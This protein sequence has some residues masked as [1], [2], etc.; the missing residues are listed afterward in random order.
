MEVNNT[1]QSRKKRKINKI[2]EDIKLNINYEK[3]DN[4]DTYGF[5]L[6][7]KTLKSDTKELPMIGSFVND[8]PDFF[9]LE[10]EVGLYHK[11]PKTGVCWFKD[12]NIIDTIDGL[13]NAILYKDIE[14]LKF[15]KTRYSGVNYFG[16]IDYSLCGDFDEE[17]L[18]H[19]IKRQCITYLWLTYEMEAI[20]FPL[21]TY[22]DERSLTWCFE[23]IMEGSNV[24]VSLK[25]VMT[26][27]EKA[28]FLKALRVLVDT[29]HPKALIVYTV[30]KYESTIQMLQ[31][32]I[33]KG[34]KIIEVPNTMM[35]KNRGVKNG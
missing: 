9:A 7:N 1:F 11:T 24:L 27:P 15:Y 22:G 21:M 12:E 10:P 32:A 19:N 35:N 25:M 34:V 26:G 2:N 5:Y 14:L 33:M 30:A 4:R 23:H 20:V 3:I 17:S 28:M 6:T 13:V 8:Y 16:P 29:R 18:V 31:Y